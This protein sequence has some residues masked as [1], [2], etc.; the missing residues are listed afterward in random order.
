MVGFYEMLVLSSRR[1]RPPG[2]R[3]ISIWTKICGIPLEHALFAGGI[4]ETAILIAKIEELQKLDACEKYLRRLNAKEVDGSAKL[5][6][7]DYEFQ[8]P[9][10]RRE[11]TVKRENLNGE[12]HGD[13]EEFRPEESE[14]DADA[15][16]DFWSIQGYFIYRH[17]VEPRV[18]FFVPREKIIPYLQDLHC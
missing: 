2:R 18:Q 8:E 15:R 5:S 16:K 4:L 17:H 12:S 6:G 7:R 11:S 10:L 1:P 13:R 14:D 9:T 3:E